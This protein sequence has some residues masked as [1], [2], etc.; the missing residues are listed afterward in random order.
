MTVYSS[1]I[2]KM[3][4]RGKTHEQILAR[5]T[6]KELGQELLEELD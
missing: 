6:N 4:T 1:F 3:L 5:L 2:K